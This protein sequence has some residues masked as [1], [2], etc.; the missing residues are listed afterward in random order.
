LEVER[1]AGFGSE[2]MK[3]SENDFAMLVKSAFWEVSAGLTDWR[4]GRGIWP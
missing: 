3:K 4:A 1:F 2:G